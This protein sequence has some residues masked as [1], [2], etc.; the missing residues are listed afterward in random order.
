MRRLF[1]HFLWG[2]LQPLVFIINLVE[3]RKRPARLH[4]L[5]NRFNILPP[6]DRELAVTEMLK[7]FYH[8]NNHSFSPL[9]VQYLTRKC[10][11][12]SIRW[13]QEQQ[14]VKVYTGIG[15]ITLQHDFCYMQFHL[16]DTLQELSLERV[17]KAAR[18]HDL[19]A[20]KYH[21]LVRSQKLSLA[22]MIY[23]LMLLMHRR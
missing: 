15:M 13:D 19:L 2:L 22:V 4:Y 7:L 12:L 3:H 1:S 18:E 23:F 6:G 11:T 16:V 20:A 9:A 10:P 14:Q 8:P 5:V 21:Q 17:T